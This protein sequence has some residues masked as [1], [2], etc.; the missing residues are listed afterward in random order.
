MII[1]TSEDNTSEDNSAS[2]DVSKAFAT[3]VTKFYKEG[4][5]DG[6]SGTEL[7]ALMHEQ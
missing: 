2:G 4:D 1:S 5:I 6:K 3:L 7:E